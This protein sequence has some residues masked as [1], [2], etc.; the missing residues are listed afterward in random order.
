MEFYLSKILNFFM[1]PL[2]ILSIIIL[3]QL[4]II[5]FTEL[6]KLVICHLV[7]PMVITKCIISED[8]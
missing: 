5:F 7:I 4:F 8:E 1:N 3:I 6:K 2:Y